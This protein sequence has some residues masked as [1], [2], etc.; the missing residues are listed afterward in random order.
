VASHAKQSFFVKTVPNL[1][2][3]Y[4]AEPYPLLSCTSASEISKRFFSGSQG[5]QVW[6]MAFSA[7]RHAK[8][9]LVTLRCCL[10]S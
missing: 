1:I 2:F 9:Y 8:L 6:R 5:L 7:D 10:I 3:T 4:L